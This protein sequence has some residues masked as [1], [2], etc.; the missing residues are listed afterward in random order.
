MATKSELLQKIAM[1]RQQGNQIDLT[2]ALA[3]VLEAAINGTTIELSQ[4]VSFSDFTKQQAMASLGINEEQMTALE[5]DEYDAIKIQ[6]T[7]FYKSVSTNRED[8]FFA[9][10]GCKSD[11]VTEVYQMEFDTLGNSYTIKLE[12]T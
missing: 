4:F 5:N 8:G 9:I 12:E 10:Y 3:D 7:K 2:G 6:D 11:D 1:L